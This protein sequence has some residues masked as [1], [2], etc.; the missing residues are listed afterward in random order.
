MKRFL[1]SQ[2]PQLDFPENDTPNSPTPEEKK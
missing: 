2:Q 1:E